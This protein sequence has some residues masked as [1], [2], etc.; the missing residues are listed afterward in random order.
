MKLIVGLGNPGQRYRG[1]RH[2]IGFQV[3]SRLAQKYGNGPAKARFHGE[4]VE[5]QIENQR[6]LLLCPDTY[7]NN[8]GQSV[9][10]ARDFYKLDHQQLLIICDDCNLPLAKLRLRKQGSAGGQKGLQDVIHRLSDEAFARLR[11]G[12]GAPPAGW[13]LSNYV[14]SKFSKAE[15]SEMENAIDHASQAAVTW[16]V[17]GIDRS[18]NLFN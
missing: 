14:L 16:A 17:E 4:V 10:G 6:V 3:V 15:M 18:M 8:S 12:V 13:H 2:N 1:T 9:L 5:A 11:I 7:M